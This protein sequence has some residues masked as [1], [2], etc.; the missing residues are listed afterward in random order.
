MPRT[1]AGY[2][3]NVRRLI[4]TSILAASAILTVVGIA[5]A[6]TDVP[7]QGAG[8]VLVA[9]LEGPVDP[10]MLEFVE[11]VVDRA[12]S[13]SF[14]AI[15]FELD[16]P[17]GLSTSM[18]DIVQEIVG[19]ELPV[20]VYVSP[21]GGRAA[22]AGVF[23]TYAAD[24]AAMAPGTNIGSATPIAGNGQEL[25]E[26]LRKKVINDSVARITELADERDRDAQFAEDAIREAEN[27]GAR[28]ALEAGVVEYI[29][30]DVRELLEVSDGTT[31]Q[32]KDL[33]LNLADASLE[34]MEPSLPLRILKRLVDPN[35]L[36]LLFGAGLIGL[37]FELTHPGS[38]L[39]GIAGG[40]CLLLALFGLSVLPA[41]GTGIALLVLA[42]ALFA[43]ESVAPGGGIL[44]VGGAVALLLGALLLF[45][46]S[47]EYGVS[48][49]LAIGMSIAIGGFFILVMRKAVQARRWR[50]P[51]DLEFMVG[52]SAVVRRAI[53]PEQS[54]SVF[55]DGELWQATCDEPVEVGAS[56]L[57]DSVDGMLVRVSP[58]PEGVPATTTESE[59]MAR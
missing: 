14:D 6:A 33:T 27:L 12:E 32:P 23:I 34:R 38:I 7:E 30:D 20:Y 58:A 50:K 36:Y 28:A 22:S 42:T 53:G 24:V 55:V 29:V 9:P 46:D 51:N 41:T 52:M 8:R 54:G 47:S 13:D 45:D 43:A 10:V 40:I 15:V 37:A 39:P 35:L 19:T 26:D 31:V 4:I 56:V 49:A 3:L 59:E 17:G 48:P 21:S 25:P 1:V 5:V 2:D 16:T 57:V 44:G 11:R 18:D